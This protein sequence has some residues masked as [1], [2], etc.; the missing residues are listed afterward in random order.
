M[1]IA[2]LLRTFAIGFVA[3]VLLVPISLIEGKISERQ[4]RAEGVVAS[5]AAETAGPE[6]VAGPFL[7]LTCEETYVE[8]REIKRGGKA[9]TVTE[10]KT[11]ACPTGYFPP[12]RLSVAASMPVE[13]LYRGIY[14]IRT[15]RATLDFNGEVEWPAP[16]ASSPGFARTWK[17]A[18]YVIAVSDPRGIRSAT[19][20]T[21]SS[22]SRSV[23]DG[24]DRAFAIQEDLGEYATRKKGEPLAFGFRVQLASTGSLH[25]A[26]V[27]DTT[28]IRI[29]SDWPHPSFS[30]AWSPDERTVAPQGFRATWR[31]THLATGG[32]ALWESHLR[33]NKVAIPQ[34]AAG[35]NLFDPVNVY[36][37]SYRATEYAFLFILFT[38]AAL[39]LVET[40]TGVRLHPIQYALVGSAIAVFFLL[41]IALSEHIHFSRA[42]AGAAAACVLLIAAYLRPALR[43][44][45]RT[46]A[47]AA[48]FGAL[49]AG[50][51]VMLS[52]EDNALL[53]G[54]LMV[55]AL[56]AV[57]MIA[58]RKLDW[59][60][61]P[62]FTKPATAS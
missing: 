12:R 48:L 3:L 54:S 10:T 44:L 51:Y 47:M 29:T 20:S 15:Y 45:A 41:L 57:T 43:T 55:F 24:P 17:K 19:T 18:Y 21:S 9:E 36:T 32:Q 61:F 34:N 60:Q 23:E 13:S 59:G 8:E 2:L 42:Y 33:N 22:L 14:R 4:R 56:L 7:A 50:L 62:F 16:P 31:T 58:T 11:R 25:I 5:Y 46:S 53:L 27:G 39:A 38:F 6:V 49:Y 37:L 1:K 35:V 28:E 30:G 26:P 40:L 52:S